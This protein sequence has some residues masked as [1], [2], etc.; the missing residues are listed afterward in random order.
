MESPVRALDLPEDLA[1]L[2]KS[3]GET[4]ESRTVAI[5]TLRSQLLELPKDDI[6]S[7]LSDRSLIRYIRS[8]KYNLDKA[9]KTAVE[10]HRYRKSHPDWFEVELEVIA[11]F[12]RGIK[13]L[14]EVDSQKRR[15]II[16]MP[17]GMIDLIDSDFMAKYPL[18]ITKFRSWMFEQLSYDPYAQVMGVVLI[19]SF[20]G[21]S[22][23]NSSKLS[24]LSSFYQH[25]ESIRFASSCVGLRLK[26][27]LLFEEPF[28]FT[29]I[30]QAA[31]FILSDKMRNRFEFGGSRYDLVKEKIENWQILPLCIGGGATDD[32]TEG[33]LIRSFV[34]T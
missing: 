20:Q 27:V 33:N 28:F 3:I 22:L 12:T 25:S 24:Q 31:R 5:G 29:L 14:S 1:E 10:N 23:W 18:A 16:V 9:L 13:I 21:I 8:R 6:P 4:E 32:L 17:S 19:I 30:W 34:Q 11:V 26:N 2:A 15:V 7:D